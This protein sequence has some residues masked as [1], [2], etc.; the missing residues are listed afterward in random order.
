[1]RTIEI[2]RYSHTKKGEARGK[3]SH[4]S[5]SGVDLAR[6]VGGTTGPFDLVLTSAI[7]RTLETAIAMGFGVHVQVPAL[8][9][10]SPEVHDE[11]G[12]HQ[13]WAWDDPF[14]EF[15]SLT[16]RGGATA[17]MGQV[18]VAIWREALESV[19]SDGRVLVVSHGRVIEVGLVA[20][21]AEADLVTLGGPFQH[22]EGAR[23]TYGAGRFFDVQFM[24]L[25][26]DVLS[27]QHASREADR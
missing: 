2:R 25:D 19:L 8:G 12:H 17:R 24:R 9:E 27:V 11:I 18:Q 10:I 20:A 22:C 3:G 16:K 5:Q 1:M 23:L 14:V 15:A 4:L 13:R 6:R 21:V 7:P 26:A